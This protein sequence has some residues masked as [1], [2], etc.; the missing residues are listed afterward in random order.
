[1]AALAW[2]GGHARFH[3]DDVYMPLTPMFHVHGWGIPYIATAMGVKQVYPGRYEAE[4]LLKLIE[5]E[6]VTFSHCVP[7]ILHMLLGHPAAEKMDLS[8]W[9]VILGGAPN[10]PGLTKRALELGIDVFSTY[11]LSETGPILAAAQLE[12]ERLAL[13]LERQI[14]YRCKTGRPI[15]L[16]DIRVVDESG[17]EIPHDGKATG[18]IVVR[19]P[20][21]TMGYHRQPELSDDLWRDGYLHTG[22][23]ATV[24]ED[25]FLKITDRLKD[26]IKSGGEW[27]S[28][29]ELERLVSQLDGVGEVAAI[30]VPHEKWGER[31]LVLVVPTTV[32]ANELQPDTVIAYLSGCADRGEISKWA[33]PDAVL[34]VEAIAKTS[35]GKIDKKALR[36]EFS[37]G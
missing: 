14:E 24:D 25:G 17:Q 2:N 36:R 20:W 28:S 9:T 4:T 7:T 18:E 26:V 32:G 11:G 6:G 22:D 19:A 3:R 30:G 5:R 21:L 13:P 12:A 10:P 29:I 23:I 34:L 31:P 8:N 37:S 16:V 33:V 35:V 15:P 1:M 27:I